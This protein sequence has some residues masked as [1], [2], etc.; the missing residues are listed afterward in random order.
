MRIVYVEDNQANVFLVRRV[1]RAGGHDVI[2]YIDGEEALANIV[3]DKPDLILMDIQLA[4]ELSGLQ[5]VEKLR[6]DGFEV[7]IVAVT[8][9]AMIG[10]RE[11][12]MDAGCTDY[13]AKPLSIPR[14]LELIEH[15]NVP[16][17]RATSTQTAPVV[18]TEAPPAAAVVA[19]SVQDDARDAMPRPAQ[20]TAAP[21]APSE[22][23]A[24]PPPSIAPPEKTTEA[25]PAGQVSSPATVPSDETTE[26]AV[27]TVTPESAQGE[28]RVSVSIQETVASRPAGAAAAADDPSTRQLPAVERST[29]RLDRPDE[30]K[31]ASQA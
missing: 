19:A 5:V 16:S 2:N 29:R 10:D 26:A 12:C 23:T 11:R 15:Y 14:L 30:E 4:G 27:S 6:K 25:I 24:S 22:T 9:Y 18:I 28:D 20:A 8:A 3:Q 31:P 13:I 7:P 1:A 21:P 17:P